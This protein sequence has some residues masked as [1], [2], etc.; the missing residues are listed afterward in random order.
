M[1]Q[2]A[3]DFQ[4]PLPYTNQPQSIPINNVVKKY[5]NWNKVTHLPMLNQN[6]LIFPPL[7]DYT[8]IIALKYLPQYRYYTN[9]SFKPPK[10][11]KPHIRKKERTGYGIYNPH[12]KIIQKE[13]LWSLQNI[14]RAELIA[15][16][17]TIQI[18]IE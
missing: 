15:I 11:I 2:I 13:R 3:T 1:L 18:I 4:I 9:G 5:T 17:H 16:Y 6:I 12:D 8:H 14:L 7:P 10:E